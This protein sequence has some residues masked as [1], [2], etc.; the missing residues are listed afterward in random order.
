MRGVPSEAASQERFNSVLRPGPSPGLPFVHDHLR[1][2][3]SHELRYILEKVAVSAQIHST[4]PEGPDRLCCA[5]MTRG[6]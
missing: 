5:H 4:V 2:V 3:I 1:V 6:G